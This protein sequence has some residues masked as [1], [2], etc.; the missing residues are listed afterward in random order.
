M[1]VAFADGEQ[2]GT[3]VLLI[4]RRSTHRP[5]RRWPRSRTTTRHRVMDG[6][7]DLHGGGRGRR[8]G[9]ARRCRG[10]PPALCRA[11]R[12]ADGSRRGRRHPIGLDTQASSRH[13]LKMARWRYRAAPDCRTRVSI[14]EEIVSLVFWNQLRRTRVCGLRGN[15]DAS[16]SPR[17]LSLIS[18]SLSA[19]GM[20]VGCTARTRR[21]HSGRP[22]GRRG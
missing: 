3:L 11:R 7:E 21:W 9:T 15:P 6:R 12:G 19:P 16:P 14:F 20:A 4:A 13:T 5:R 10:F 2:P 8:P 17:A 18:R 1:V 22:P